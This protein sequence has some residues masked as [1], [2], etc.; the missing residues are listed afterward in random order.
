MILNKKKFKWLVKNE[1]EI[2]SI[3]DLITEVVMNKNINYF[4]E[5]FAG[6]ISTAVKLCPVLY[7]NGVKNIIVNNVN[8]TIVNTYIYIKDNLEE[9]F[10]AYW[11]E[12]NR[13]NQLIKI[14]SNLSE[15][16][17][18]EQLKFYYNLKRKEYNENMYEVSIHQSAL[19]LFLVN[20][21]L[22][23]V[24]SVNSKEEYVAPF[25]NKIHIF[26]KESRYKTFLGYSILFN[27]F[28]VIFEKMNPFNFINKYKIHHK[29]AIFYFDPDYSDNIIELLD[30]KT[31]KSEQMSFIQFYKLF[32]YLIIKDENIGKIDKY[33]IEKIGLNIFEGY[34]LKIKKPT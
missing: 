15:E 28:N 10:N 32:D 6:G 33:E 11:E 7:K 22:N 34:Y 24:Y 12:E 4:I 26:E 18:L 21:S 20:R 17:I 16:K 19:F 8:Q 25:S 3:E 13:F 9:I 1:T 30:K 5:P 29:E 14:H 31:I 2:K 27:K 23:L